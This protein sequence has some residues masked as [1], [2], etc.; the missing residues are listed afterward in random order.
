MNKVLILLGKLFLICFGIA[1][2]IGA[3]YYGKETVFLEKQ[4]SPIS[5]LP[6]SPTVISPTVTPTLVATS[7]GDIV[8]AKKKI[9]GGAILHQLYTIDILPG[10]E[11]KRN[12]TDDSNDTLVIQK[13]SYTLTVK[14]VNSGGGICSF[15]D[16]EVE[17]GPFVNQIPKDTYTD[18]KGTQGE[19]YRRVDT[20]TE[21]KGSFEICDKRQDTYQT[22][23]RYGMILYETPVEPDEITLQNMDMMVTSLRNK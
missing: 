21:A 19:M 4:S 3:Y 9:D 5:T 10:W 1:V 14:Q 7:S 16:S 6:I 8:I 22:P 2:V 20:S 18:L 15:P 23:T 12:H 17:E 11:T 13:G